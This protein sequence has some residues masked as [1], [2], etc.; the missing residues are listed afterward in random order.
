MARTKLK[1]FKVYLPAELYDKLNNRADSLSL[2]ANHL[3]IYLIG[4]GLF[5][6]LP[7]KTGCIDVSASSLEG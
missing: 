7:V 2:S 5:S 3:A 4:S 6:E 1:L